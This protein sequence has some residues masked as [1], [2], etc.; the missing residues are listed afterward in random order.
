MRKLGIT[1]WRIANMVT[2]IGFVGTVVLATS[3]IRPVA[4]VEAA[5]QACWSCWAGLA[6][7][8]ED[9]HQ[10]FTSGQMNSN[11]IFSGTAHTGCA[12]MTG[13]G[14]CYCCLHDECMRLDLMAQVEKATAAQNGMVTLA[15][16]IRDSTA[17]RFNTA[18]SSIQIAGCDGEAASNVPLTRVQVAQLQRALR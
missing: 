3:A 8:D 17:L 18:R 2:G 6:P 15:R 4:E 9:E 7:C 13:P 10:D 14:E 1:R 11:P 12:P 16:L 5:T